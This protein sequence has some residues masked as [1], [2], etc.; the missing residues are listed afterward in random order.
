MSDCY[1]QRSPN[2]GG[3]KTEKI[4]KA[5]EVEIPLLAGREQV[6]TGQTLG[7]EET[8][9]STIGSRLDED[10]DNVWKEN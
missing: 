5:T 2:T 7:V 4:G 8:K 10:K 6:G 1:W 9:D 3:D